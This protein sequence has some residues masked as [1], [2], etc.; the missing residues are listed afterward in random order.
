MLVFVEGPR[1][2]NMF[3]ANMFDRAFL[4]KV[5]LF[6]VNKMFEGA[7]CGGNRPCRGRWRRLLHKSRE[8]SQRHW[9]KAVTVRRVSVTRRSHLEVGLVVNWAHI[10][11]LQRRCLMADVDQQ[12]LGWPQEKMTFAK[13]DKLR[14]V[15]CGPGTLINIPMWAATKT[16]LAFGRCEWWQLAG[17]RRA[18]SSDLCT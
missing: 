14:M 15:V 16:N 18:C 11:T 10:Q 6:D 5:Q 7:K 3:D 2:V 1:N 12:V 17:C 13:W 9:L 8:T 4:W